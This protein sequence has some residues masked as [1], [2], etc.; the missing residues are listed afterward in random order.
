ML[1][2]ANSLNNDMKH[3]HLK[4]PS[5]K[6]SVIYL[7]LLVVAFALLVDM[8]T[9]FREVAKIR[10]SFIAEIGQ[11][12]DFKW[13]PG[14]E[15]KDYKQET[16]QVPA[17]FQNVKKQ[18]L[19]TSGELGN[20]E[21]SL[22]IARHLRQG[23]LKGNAI[24]SSTIETYKVMLAEG[25]GYCADYTQVFNAI[26]HAA[27]IPVR[28][29]GT[30]FDGFGAGHALSE[31]YD[32]SLKKWVLID[33]FYSFYVT[34]KE[35]QLPMSVLEFI[36]VLRDGKRER[37]IVNPIVKKYFG[38]RD[39]GMLFDYFDRGVDQMFLWWGNDVYTYDAH[40]VVKIFSLAGR[41]AEQMAAILIGIH[42][43]IH[44]I[45]TDTNAED[46]KKLFTNRTYFFILVAVISL[47]GLALLRQFVLWVR[48]K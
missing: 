27:K 29:W 45:P 3:R 10:N 9:P 42:P 17:F 33:T 18:I 48:R 30:A 38:F 7:L 28:E 47:S 12:G 19:A 46:I 44:I 24:K 2:V 13:L 32:E 26:A 6:A 22:V 34:D 40:P 36:N 15:P 21:K 1:V 8:I 25:E 14:N 4:S 37:I 43:K 35:T 20:F 11:E 5:I 23:P 31:I 16:Q 39:E 41:A